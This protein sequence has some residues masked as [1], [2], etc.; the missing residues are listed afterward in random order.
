MS[1]KRTYN[2][3]FDIAWELPNSEYEDAHEALLHEREKV[4]AALLK[5][6]QALMSGRYPREYLEAIGHFDTFEEDAATTAEHTTTEE[7]T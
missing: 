6:I 1:D 3:A 7:T 2:H 4:F 5:R